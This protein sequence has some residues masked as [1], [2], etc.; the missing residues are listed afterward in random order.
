MIW[1]NGLFVFILQ[2]KWVSSVSTTLHCNKRAVCP[3]HFLVTHAP[4]SLCLSLLT[5][6]L[7]SET[8]R[9]AECHAADRHANRSGIGDEVPHWNGL[10][11]QT[12][13]GAQG[14][15]AGAT[16]SLSESIPCRVKSEESERLTQRDNLSVI[17]VLPTTMAC[18]H[19]GNGSNGNTLLSRGRCW[20]TPILAARCPASDHFRRTRL[21]Q[22]TLH[23]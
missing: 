15:G 12:A 2:I 21:R 8:R 11:A 10:R 14:K 6:P 4:P 7:T 17:R 5:P 18:S 20:L 22:S 16:L 1:I 23:W 19:I 3:P 9:P 13:G